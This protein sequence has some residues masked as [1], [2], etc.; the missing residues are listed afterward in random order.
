MQCQIKDKLLERKKAM[1][2]ALNNKTKN[3]KFKTSWAKLST[4]NANLIKKIKISLIECFAT[5]KEDG[6][7]I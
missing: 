4:L 1:V 5:I 3:E 6:E 2:E 7:E